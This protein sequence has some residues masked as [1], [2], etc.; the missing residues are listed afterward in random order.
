M[1][2]VFCFNIAGVLATVRVVDEVVGAWARE[3]R[4]VPMTL[5][6]IRVLA[7]EAALGAL[8]SSSARTGE[9]WEI[10]IAADGT[11]TERVHDAGA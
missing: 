11:S 7:A 10:R 2:H 4:S 9:I 8:R 5:A 6:R 3:S 1:T